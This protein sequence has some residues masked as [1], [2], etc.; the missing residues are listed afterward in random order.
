[1]LKAGGGSCKGSAPSFLDIIMP[2]Y[3]G[4]MGWIGSRIRK[5][6][7]RIKRDQR[8]DLI[9]MIRKTQGVGTSS[10]PR[11]YS[12]IKQVNELSPGGG[13]VCV[14]TYEMLAG[15]IH[16]APQS[17]NL[18]LYGFFGRVICFSGR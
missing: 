1:M 3:T 9:T 6:H 5:I 18:V 12:S 15:V 17:M 7:L 11:A 13:R 4:T 10:P 8:L 16:G 14:R 2:S